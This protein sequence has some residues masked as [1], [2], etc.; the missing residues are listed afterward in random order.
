LQPLN[1][2]F[3]SINLQLAWSTGLLA[4]VFFVDPS[5]PPFLTLL[6]SPTV[7]F[8]VV[9]LSDLIRTATMHCDILLTTAI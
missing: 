6:V 9:G 5:S 2:F 7:V 1:S 8:A 3:S 4:A